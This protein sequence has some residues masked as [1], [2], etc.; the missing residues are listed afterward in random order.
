M[1][2]IIVTIFKKEFFFL[3]GTLFFIAAWYFQTFK[4]NNY[5]DEI[6]FYHRERQNYQELSNHERFLS[7]QA[8]DILLKQND[9][10]EV[11]K[12]TL[13][14]RKVYFN[15]QIV[16]HLE[17]ATVLL[18]EITALNLIQRGEDAIADENYKYD[19]ALARLNQIISKSDLDSFTNVN[20]LTKY[21]NEILLSA[22]D[23]VSQKRMSVDSIYFSSLNEGAKNL[24]RNTSFLNFYDNL[25][26]GFFIAA[27]LLVTIHKALKYLREY[28]K[29]Q[30][31]ESETEENET[32]T[33][34]ITTQDK[35]SGAGSVKKANTFKKKKR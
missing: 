10:V 21:A 28:R 17:E 27:S 6:E 34:S 19:T 12:D 24:K 8:D 15:R 33:R 4:I 16:L 32:I 30:K 31:G 3:L 26:I 5:K 9:Y 35:A 2:Q 22:K 23:F 7:T 1:K 11:F 29:P 25:S 14:G 20:Q 18:T 13:Y